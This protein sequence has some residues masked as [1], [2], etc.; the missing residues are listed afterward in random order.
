MQKGTPGPAHISSYRL[1]HS[2]GVRT[3]IIIFNDSHLTVELMKLLNAFIYLRARLCLFKCLV[4]GA[5]MQ[6]YCVVPPMGLLIEFNATCST[7]WRKLTH[8][9]PRAPAQMAS[10]RL[11][12]RRHSR[13]FHV[14]RFSL[15]LVAYFCCCNN[16]VVA[17]PPGTPFI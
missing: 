9:R 12:I 10:C 8:R 16:G 17:F 3:G 13:L 7:I 11:A 5:Q 14:Q 6:T 1:T 2:S 15:G 4:R